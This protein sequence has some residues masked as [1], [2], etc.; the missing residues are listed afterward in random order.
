M[1]EDRS[2]WLDRLL[3]EGESGT[4]E[5]KETL[6]RE[7]LETVAAFA[8]TR[9]GTL[10]IGVQD[11]GTVRGITLGKETL[12]EWANHIAQATYLHPHIG[13]L[14][15]EGKTIATVEVP[16]GSL[17]PVPCRGRYLK[18]VGKSTRQMT[19]DDLTRA[20]LGKVGMTTTSPSLIPAG[21]HPRCG[22]RNS[23]ESISQTP[24]TASSPRCSFT[25]AGSSD[26]A[27]VSRRCWT[28][29]PQRACLNL[30]LKSEQAACGS[31]SARTSSLKSTFS[32]WG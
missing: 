28:S 2:G 12:R 22:W 11:D 14:S 1:S 31:P 10:L 19:D 9:G 29:A 8:N 32:H 16:E 26:G 27:G 4:V 3:V 20:V 6:D 18:R 15:Y 17:K 24:V 7:V 5:F 25:S 30:N 23:S 13:S 21:C